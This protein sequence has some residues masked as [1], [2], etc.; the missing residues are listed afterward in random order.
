MKSI[1]DRRIVSIEMSAEWLLKALQKAG[2][3]R[4]AWDL[5]ELPDD[6][7]LIRVDVSNDLDPALTF[8]CESESLPDSF[9]YLGRQRPIPIKTQ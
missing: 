7:R 9:R 5:V 1:D 6:A 2:L 4:F 8:H 3:L